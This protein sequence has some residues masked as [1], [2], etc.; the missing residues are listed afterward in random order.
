MKSMRGWFVAIASVIPALPAAA[1]NAF[2]N[3]ETPHV[4]PLD[5]TPDGH[6]LLAVNTAD[7]RLEVFTI[8]AG[9]LAHVASI[10]VGL[11][12][13][14]VRARTNGEAWVVNHVSDSV[15]IVDLATYRVVATVDTADEPCDVAFAGS[16]VR[17]FVSC[18]APS[19]I[20]VFD[21]A[22]PQAAPTNV[23]IDAEDPRALAVSAD[24]SR[25][26]VA[27][28]E[29]GNGSTVLGGGVTMNIGFPPNVAQDP[30]GPYGG[31]NPPPNSGNAFS[32]PI[33]AGLATPP[34]VSQIVK[35]DALD[36]WMDDN[37]R[38]WTS[39][40]SGANAGLS[41][42]PVGW[43]LADRDVAILDANTL[44]VAY[45]TRLMNI[46]MALAVSPA[47]GRVMVVGTDATNEVRFEP[48]V[49][50]TFVRV[51]AARI[52]GTTGALLGNVDLN[53]HLTYAT[54]TVPQTDRDRSIGDPRGIAWNAA[55]T[56]AYVAGMGS[57]NLVVLDAN[58]A[59]AGLASTIEVGEGPTGVVFHAASNRV[60]VLN[61]FA[62]TIS[63]VNVATELV[64]NTVS[65]H[66][67]SPLAI[68]VG[69]KHLYDT[70]KTSGLGQVACASCHVDGRMD[71]LAWDLGDP[72]GD[73]K[74]TTGQ[75]LGGNFPGLNTGFQA[76][77]PMKGPMTTQTLQ[78]IIGKEPLHWRGDRAGLE[79]FNGAFENLQ[80]D[81][82]QLTPAEM[83]EYENFLATIIFPPNPFRNF[84]NTLPTSLATGQVSPGRFSPKGTPLPI[85]D[86][87]RG[88]QIYRPPF[89]LDGGA[90]AC[91][92]CHNLPTGMGTD[93]RFIG[94]SWQPFPIGPNG[95]HHH[96]LVS[97]D[98]F[99][100]V[101]IKVPQLRNLYDKVGFE[102]YTTNSRSG[103]GFV[104]DG[105]VD[106]I[107]QFVAEPI[108]N[109]TSDQDI[110][111]MTAFMLAFS[112]SDLPY[113]GSILEPPATASK[114]THAAVGAQTTVV[115]SNNP[116]AGQFT[117]IGNMLALADANK[118]A[119]VVKGRQGGIAR[120]YSYLGGGVFQ[121]DRAAEQVNSLTL[122]GNAAP[123]SELTWTVVPK[124]TQTRI[125][126]DRDS[127]GVFDR[128]ELDAGSDPADGGST[129]G[130][131]SI[132]NYGNGCAGSGGYVPELSLTGCAVAGGNVT[133]GLA[134]ALGGSSA[135]LFVGLGQGQQSLPAG[136][137]LV[138]LPLSPLVVGPLPLG[139]AGAGN[140]G[141]SLPAVI[142]A[143]SP[144]A[145][146]TLQAF[147]PDAGVPAQF[148]NSNGVLLG[149]Q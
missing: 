130:C 145:T 109:M 125:G 23:A 12:P 55:G 63:I 99:T 116:G 123:G 25:V 67:P 58:G 62:A 113:G 129:P 98:G 96:M 5:A 127:D 31:Q 86:A 53:S 59:R 77:H 7:D 16:A 10:P 111:D 104:H 102:T 138:T 114:D 135:L 84:D 72:Q 90:I 71:R 122:R 17:A 148:C 18:S 9:S 103:F 93:N 49:N 91:S 52:D 1:Q 107:A 29:S 110:A 26:Y 46:N 20:Q 68:K 32:P 27:V 132:A 136:C 39:L 13:V 35:K 147:V 6:K 101:T 28:F 73:M 108:F 51:E 134:K 66:D 105:S 133:L 33:K 120:G 44:A 64:T 41:G 78:D 65:L 50:G 88:S 2:V 38:E 131:G 119:V 112:G 85:G 79:E 4:H 92:S 137:F 81:D 24:G 43:D 74:A 95:E 30:A 143:N 80:G 118:V 142:P 117:L 22:N 14:S 47:D 94:F 100:N 21:P 76:W 3:W 15:S 8:G 97:Q 42:R 19:L 61:K 140:G 48:N 82:V 89:L 149:I 54:P 69:R 11:D 121:S 57:N 87:A 83:Q 34:K 56:R 40:V 126:I 36:R 139:G 60:F 128:D 141:F 144:P 124:G 106:T 45:A 115:D 37:N 70:H 146:I 75:N